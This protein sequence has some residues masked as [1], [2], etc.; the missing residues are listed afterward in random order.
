MGKKGHHEEPLVPESDNDILPLIPKFLGAF[1]EKDLFTDGQG[2]QAK[3]ERIESRDNKQ[4]NFIL[5]A[6][7]DLVRT[8]LRKPNPPLPAPKEVNNLQIPNPPTDDLLKSP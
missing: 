4:E 8:H 2:E 6:P 5:P 7:L 1:G 3:D